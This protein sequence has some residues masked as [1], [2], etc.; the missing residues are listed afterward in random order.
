MLQKL[1]QGCGIVSTGLGSMGVSTRICGRA[2]NCAFWPTAIWLY[3]ESEIPS[4]S[5][6]QTCRFPLCAGGPARAESLHRDRSFEASAFADFGQKFGQAW[7]ELKAAASRFRMF[8]K[9]RPLGAMTRMKSI[10]FCEFRPEVTLDPGCKNLKAMDNHG[11]AGFLAMLRGLDLRRL[12]KGLRIPHFRLKQ[13]P[14]IQ[15][16]PTPNTAMSQP[17]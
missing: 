1:V 6:N 12:S 7:S 5:L 8:R 4:P 13:E 17:G 9:V 15:L 10:Y 14:N 3:P 11:A 16:P 2:Q